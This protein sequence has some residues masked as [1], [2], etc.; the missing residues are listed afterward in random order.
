MYASAFVLGFHGCDESVGEKILAGE[1]Q[2]KVSDNKYDWLGEGIYFW[3]NSPSR[4]LHWANFIKDNPKK[5]K[6][7]IEKPFVIGAIIDLG[8]CLDLTEAGSLDYVKSGYVSLKALFDAVELPLPINKQ[9]DTHD[10]DLVLRHLDCAVI[11]HVHDL[12]EETNLAA[13][14]S[15]RG[16]FLEGAP[17]YDGARIMAKTHIQICVRYNRSIRGYFRPIPESV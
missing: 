13:Y 6:S 5:F 8:I 2:L 4:A 3:E 7:R 12:R 9:G 1:E 14:D 11:N 10:E 16:V 15:V 17:L